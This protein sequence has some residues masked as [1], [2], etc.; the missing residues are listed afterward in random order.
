ML[1]IPL[2]PEESETIRKAEETERRNPNPEMHYDPILKIT[3]YGQKRRELMQ[4]ISN[5]VRNNLLPSPYREELNEKGQFASREQR[6]TG[7]Q[8]Y[9]LDYNLSYRRISTSP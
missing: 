9:L 7:I 5:L 6:C 1:N 2:S 4:F 8:A 3:Y